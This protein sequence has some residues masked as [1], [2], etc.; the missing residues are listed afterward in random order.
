MAANFSVEKLLVAPSVVELQKLQDLQKPTPE[1]SVSSLG[2]DVDG[3]EPSTPSILTMPAASVHSSVASNLLQ[4]PASSQQTLSYFDVLFPH[5]QM[6]C[7]NP[8]LTSSMDSG[9]LQQR[10]WSQNWIELLQQSSSGQLGEN[11]TS[12][13]LQPIRKNKRIRTAFSPSQLVHLEKAFESNHYVIGNERKQLAQKLAL[14][15]TQ[16]KVWFQNRRTKQK[17]VKPDGSSPSADS[18]EPRSF[19]SADSSSGQSSPRLL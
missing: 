12:L 6:A 19:S 7:A 1:P 8:F 13:F 5:V 3:S 16:V 11:T 17:R 14:T 9:S 10:F 18:A 15:E 4:N 2:S